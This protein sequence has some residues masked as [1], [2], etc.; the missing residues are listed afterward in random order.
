M[1]SPMVTRPNLGQKITVKATSSL[2]LVSFERVSLV[3]HV[4]LPNMK[5]LS[6][7]VEK[8]KRRLKLT[9]DR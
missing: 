9:R 4:C 7:T 6:L 1:Y 8:L 2:T 5:S 3:V